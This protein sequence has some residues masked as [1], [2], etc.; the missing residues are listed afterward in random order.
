MHTFGGAKGWEVNVFAKAVAESTL[1]ETLR[2][3]RDSKR[4]K[5]AEGLG[6]SQQETTCSM[7]RKVGLGLP[8]EQ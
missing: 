4:V 5:P 8:E 7:L 6:K 3:T 2:T 1:C